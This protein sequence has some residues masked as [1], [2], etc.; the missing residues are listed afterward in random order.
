M[1]DKR[2]RNSNIYKNDIS[3]W[4]SVSLLLLLQ[5]YYMSELTQKKKLNKAYRSI[6]VTDLNQRLLVD[7]VAVWLGACD[8]TIP[9][10]G[11]EGRTGG[12]GAIA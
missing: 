3:S 1:T 6:A 7:A 11:L 5:K 9:L 8:E 12:R 2:I 10:Q 4:E